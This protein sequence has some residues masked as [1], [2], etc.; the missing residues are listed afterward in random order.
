MRTKK[1][2]KIKIT[3]QRGSPNTFATKSAKRITKET[4]PL[5]TKGQTPSRSSGSFQPTRKTL[6]SSQSCLV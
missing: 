4:N 2:T 3:N 6:T 5:F 1:K